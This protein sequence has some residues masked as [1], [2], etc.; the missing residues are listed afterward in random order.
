MTDLMVH[1][2]EYMISA[3]PVTHHEVT[4]FA[5]WVQW[6]GGARVGGDV[7]R[8]SVSSWQS[9]GANQVWHVG[10]GGWVY[11]SIP[12]ERSD[13]FLAATRYPLVRAL[14]IAREVAPMVTVNGWTPS[15]VLARDGGDR[16]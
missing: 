13:E 10:D 3:L 2:T 5:V 6:R 1:Q 4:L 9:G 12:S 16:G 8:Y 15:A 11:E 7:D 14:E